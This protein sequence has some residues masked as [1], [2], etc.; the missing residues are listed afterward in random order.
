MRFM[1]IH[2]IA[3]VPAD[4][5]AA[6][7]DLFVSNFVS[8]KIQLLTAAFER[9]DYSRY[10]VGFQVEGLFGGNGTVGVEFSSRQNRFPI[11]K[12]VSHGCPRE[13]CTR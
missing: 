9:E 6:D 12:D 2:L 1:P 10:G 7:F 13:Y 8:L 11:K 3:K 5:H 4:L